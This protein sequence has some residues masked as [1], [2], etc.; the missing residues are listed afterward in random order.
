MT[1]LAPNKVQAF[2]DRLYTNDMPKIMRHGGDGLTP[3][4]KYPKDEH[5]FLLV[6]IKRIT[7]FFLE[8]IGKV[9]FVPSGQYIEEL[10]ELFKALIHDLPAV[11]FERVLS[12][13]KA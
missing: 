6:P 8:E 12:E 9:Q 13:V 4:K 5:G 2:R 11:S 7:R 3:V 10:Y 1:I